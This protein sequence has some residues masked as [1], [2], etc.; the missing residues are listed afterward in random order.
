MTAQL[1]MPLDLWAAA[2][3]QAPDVDD[4]TAR[5][6]RGLVRLPYDLGEH[7]GGFAGQLV[8]AWV[9]CDP[10]CGGVELGAAVLDINHGCCELPRFVGQRAAGRG[11]HRVGHGRVGF[12]G[13]YH[14]PLT[15]YWQPEGQANAK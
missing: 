2:R 8:E 10:V 14:G 4:H 6:R 5:H 9:C 11:L 7:S 15:P 3:T 1:A 13:F 12:R